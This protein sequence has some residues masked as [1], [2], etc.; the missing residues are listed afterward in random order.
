[1]THSGYYSIFTFNKHF[2]KKN[3]CV[4][5]PVFTKPHFWRRLF[6][7]FYIVNFLLFKNKNSTYLM[8][9]IVT[10]VAKLI[11]ILRT[12]DDCSLFILVNKRINIDFKTHC[13][14][15]PAFCLTFFFILLSL[16]N[17]C[18]KQIL[19]T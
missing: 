1:M 3:D 17:R 6:I 11:D 10:C 4:N 16:N 9:K 19:H 15:K 13:Q 14:R 5:E 8:K 12:I 18:F 7:T 2:D